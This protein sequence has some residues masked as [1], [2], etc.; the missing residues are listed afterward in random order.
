MSGLHACAHSA[1]DLE[2]LLLVHISK[3]LQCGFKPRGVP[4]EL[5]CEV[6]CR[7]SPSDRIHQYHHSLIIIPS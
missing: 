1:P 7:R 4:G 2:Q 6:S 5:T 3:M